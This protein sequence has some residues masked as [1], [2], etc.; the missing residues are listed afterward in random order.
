MK[1][2]LNNAGL[3]LLSSLIAQCFV[4]DVPAVESSGKIVTLEIAKDYGNFVFIKLDVTPTAIPACS[5]Y[6][7]FWNYTLPLITDT[8][9]RVFA[10]LM[11]AYATQHTVLI[12]GADTCGEFGSIESAVAVRLMP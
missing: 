8:D 2:N 10:M 1:T 4:L 7:G 9:R 3:M 12:R 6:N 11:T 5:A